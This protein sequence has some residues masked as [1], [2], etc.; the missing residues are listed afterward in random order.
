MRWL[1]STRFSGREFEQ[2]LGDRTGKH[3]VLQSTGLQ[4]VGYNLVT[5]NN[6]CRS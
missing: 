4:R 2:T 3:G 5:E 6:K 1:D